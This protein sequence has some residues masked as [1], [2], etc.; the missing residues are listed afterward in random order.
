[1]SNNSIKHWL[2]SVVFSL[3]LITDN[4]KIELVILVWTSQLPYQVI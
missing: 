1:M 3:V 4:G 2:V